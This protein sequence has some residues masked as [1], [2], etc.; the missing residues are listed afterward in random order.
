MLLDERDMTR[1]DKHPLDYPAIIQMLR[2]RGLLFENEE[3]AI[4]FLHN[5]SYFR[6]AG[7]MRPMERDK[8]LHQ[9]KS[10]SYFENA[11]L[12]Y[13]F[14]KKL[15]ALVFTALQYIEIALRSKMIH[16]IALQYGSFWFMD[17]NLAVN[18][19]LY[20]DN[21]ARIRQELNRSKEDF[22]EDHAHRYSTPD[23][24][25][26][27]KTFE[28]LSFG[29]LSRLYCNFSDN[30]VK[31]RIAREFNLPNHIILES[32]IKCAV[33]LRNCIAH[34]ARIW[35]RKFPLKPQLPNRLRGVWI[36]PAITNRTK[37]Y[38]QLC[39]V[40]YFQNSLIPNNDFRVRLKALL[41]KYP[42]ADTAAMGFPRGW[43]G[44]ALW[45]QSI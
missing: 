40:A 25:P 4:K 23:M 10:S 13:E 2:G 5:V 42:N 35:N 20:V 32:W 28:V 21:I 6:I 16:Y 15:R 8:I 34:H 30:S 3:R 33:V 19:R 26:V 27:W 22:I 37:L 39:Y 11:I 14:D 43:E 44:E 45:G 1:Y 29:M 12:L 7:Y 24:P 9:F 36:H 18:Q 38:A 41:A 17:N 31:K